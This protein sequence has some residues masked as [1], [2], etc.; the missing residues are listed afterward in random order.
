MMVAGPLI[1]DIESGVNDYLDW[2]G[3]RAP[4]QLRA[5]HKDR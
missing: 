2:D 3:S 5:V 1:V 4:V